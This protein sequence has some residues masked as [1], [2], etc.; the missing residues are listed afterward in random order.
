MVSCSFCMPKYR[1][2]LLLQGQPTDGGPATA[3]MAAPSTICQLQLVCPLPCHIGCVSHPPTA[4]P[5][6]RMPFTKIHGSL[7]SLLQFPLSCFLPPYHINL[8]LS[9][10]S[11]LSSFYNISW[12][13][14]EPPTHKRID[15][16][17][18]QSPMYNLLSCIDSD[19][20][21]PSYHFLSPSLH[22]PIPCNDSHM[23]WCPP[24]PTSDLHGLYYILCLLQLPPLILKPMPSEFLSLSML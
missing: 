9:Y 24:D 23:H 19:D 7:K 2:S 15:E 1:T 3:S 16:H 8:F 22:H 5:S 11:T 13:Y 12:V 20:P 14:M 21:L 4:L 6:S 17:P 10:E 18:L